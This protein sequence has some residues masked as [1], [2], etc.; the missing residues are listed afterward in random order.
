MPDN[1]GKLTAKDK[2]TILAWLSQRWTNQE[3]PFH[4]G[5]TVWELG[6]AIGTH[7]FAGGGGG[8]PGSGVQFGGPTYPLIVVTCRTC[9]HVV[10]INAI[11]VGIV[12]MGPEPPQSTP[13]PDP[14]SAP[15]AG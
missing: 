10:L 7:P 3:C 2:E 8:V 9:G 15:E 14:S 6:D 4:A 1:Q 13:P 5:P 12:T 11:T